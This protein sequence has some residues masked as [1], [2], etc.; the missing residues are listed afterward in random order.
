MS[1]FFCTQNVYNRGSTSAIR[2]NR[3]ILINSNEVCIFRSTRDHGMAMNLGRQVRNFVERDIK[4]FFNKNKIGEKSEMYSFIFHS[5]PFQRH[6]RNLRTYM[7]IA[8][9]NGLPICTCLLI[10]R[11]GQSSSSGQKFF[12]IWKLPLSI[13]SIN[14]GIENVHPWDEVSS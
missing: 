12:I 5:R 2:H 11:R 7:K 14:G 3:D 10:R 8:W 4:T 6:S 9:K 13:C 1:V